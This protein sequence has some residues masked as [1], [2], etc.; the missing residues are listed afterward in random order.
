MVRMKRLQKHMADPYDKGGD[1]SCIA[2]K[3]NNLRDLTTNRCSCVIFLGILHLRCTENIRQLTR[4][5]KILVYAHFPHAR[6]HASSCRAL[7]SDFY[8]A[9]LQECLAKSI[10]RANDP[11]TMFGS[12]CRAQAFSDY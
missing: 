4:N 12:S 5:S 11:R 10:R 1:S 3:Y 6:K 7:D 2:S 8:C 9:D